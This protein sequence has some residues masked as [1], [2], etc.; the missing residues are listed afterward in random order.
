MKYLIIEVPHEIHKKI[1]ERNRM[2]S[3]TQ[4]IDSRRFIFIAGKL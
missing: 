2:C 1:I 4:R 3:R